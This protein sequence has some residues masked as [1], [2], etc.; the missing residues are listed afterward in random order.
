MYSCVTS[1]CCIHSVLLCS[2]KKIACCCFFFQ[3]SSCWK[4]SVMFSVFENILLKPLR[5]IM[6][7]TI[8]YTVF[9]VVH[10]ETH[11]TN[12]LISKFFISK[13]LFCVC[14]TF[15]V[16]TL[17]DVCCVSL[18]EIPMSHRFKSHLQKVVLIKNKCMIL[19]LQPQMDEKIQ[20]GPRAQ[21]TWVKG[22]SGGAK[23]SD[24]GKMT[25]DQDH[26]RLKYHFVPYL[27]DLEA[28]CDTKS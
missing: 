23:A 16:S 13:L 26:S 9:C 11:N 5:H 28:H 22:S 24:S 15:T 4:D 7:F 10:R 12:K 20:L 27:F 17:I 8:L 18:R 14:K 6:S 25:T 21:V 19:F 3:S 2:K 1:L